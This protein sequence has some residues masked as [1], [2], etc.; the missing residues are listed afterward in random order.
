MN[1]KIMCVFLILLLISLQ[2]FTS[3]SFEHTTIEETRKHIEDIEES[4][5]DIAEEYGYTLEDAPKDIYLDNPYAVKAYIVTLDENQ[6]IVVVISNDCRA[7]DYYNNDDYKLISPTL[8][9]ELSPES[10]VERYYI[11]NRIRTDEREQ[12]FAL[13]FVVALVNAVSGRQTTKEECDE[14]LN[15]V[16]NEDRSNITYSESYNDDKIYAS[17]VLNF[18]DDYHIKYTLNSDNVAELCLWGLTATNI[19][20]LSCS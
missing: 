12:D 20:K 8:D 10:G 17:R 13:D 16:F 9:S 7:N 15:D 11:Y 3:C 19:V 2:V 6:D 18:W 1:K 14:F 4:L 5:E